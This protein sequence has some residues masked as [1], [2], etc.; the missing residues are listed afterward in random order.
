VKEIPAW[1]RFEVGDDIIVN[2]MW[3][4]GKWPARIVDDHAA[5]YDGP[6]SGWFVVKRTDGVT[7]EFGDEWEVLV[8]CAEKPA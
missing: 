1:T 7:H 8:T 6:K 4:D 5:Y 2:N 3:N